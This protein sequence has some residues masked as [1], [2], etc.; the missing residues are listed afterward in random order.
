MLGDWFFMHPI[1]LVLDNCE[2]LIEATAQLGQA[3]L[4][5]CPRLHILATS[6][7]RLGLT[8]EVVWRVPSLPCPDPQNLPANAQSAADYA[9][10][11]PAVQLFVERVAQVRPEFQWTALEDI[12]AAARIC[13][14]LDGIPLALELAAARTQAL[15]LPQIALRLDDRFRLLVGGSRTALPRQ[16]TLRALIEW[17]YELLSEPERGLLCRLSVFTGGWTLEAAEYVD[18]GDALGLLASLVEKSLV[19]A[20]DLPAGRRYRMLETVREYAQERLRESGGEAVARQAH[21]D[22]FLRLAQETGPALRGADLEAALERVEAEVGNFREALQWAQTNA[23]S[24][25]ASLRLSAALWPFWE[26]RGHHTE[27]REHLRA[28]L[29]RP[30]GL[31]DT[32]ERAQ[33]LLG[34]ATLAFVQADWVAVLSSGRESVHLFH[35]LEDSRGLA[36]GLL[37][38]GYASGKIG[39][40]AASR[41]LLTEALARARECGW[42]QGTILAFSY[43]GVTADLEGDLAQARSF[44]EQSVALAEATGDVRALA[45]SLHYTG[46]ILG[47]LALKTGDDVRLHTLLERSLQQWRRL[48]DT[49]KAALTLCILGDVSRW[50][51]GDPVLACTYYEEAIEAWRDQGNR[52]RLAAA[53]HEMGNALFEQGEYERARS[54]YA[55]SLVLFDQL[56]EDYGRDFVRVNLGNTLFHLGEPVAAR[57]LFRE[58]LPIYQQKAVAEGMVW[59]LER[60]A[61]VE[62]MY[63]D[64]GPAVRLLGAASTARRALGI[65]LSR[66]DQADWEQALVSVRGALEAQDFTSLWAEGSAWTL[67]QAVAY[68]LRTA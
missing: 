66:S 4:E 35:R 61:V 67:E 41:A 14:R 18:T 48:G 24:S 58:A 12:Q 29:T 55:E 11:Y 10:Q 46:R 23:A 20:E 31:A 16:Q 13:H 26:V 56:E 65:P 5:Q 38:L 9:R 33:A 32:P 37:L 42:D 6:R 43:L 36:A 30:G 68:A 44:W 3:L 60:L 54:A 25:D 63:G 64:A 22:Y 57:H 21:L 8:G 51:Q 49:H 2:H 19:L 28:A 50:R 27:G 39:E 34:A 15:S 17:S 7:Q 59:T 45:L 47:H 52:N 40:L 62:A 1:L 53:L